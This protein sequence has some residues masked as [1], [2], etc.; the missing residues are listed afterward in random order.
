[1]T[2]LAFSTTLPAQQMVFQDLFHASSESWVRDSY[3]WRGAWLHGRHGHWCDD[4]DGLPID[5][6]SMEWPCPCP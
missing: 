4:W 2:V 1:M 5:E 6:T 3:R